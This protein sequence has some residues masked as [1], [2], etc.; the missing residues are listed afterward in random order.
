VDEQKRL[1]LA[2][3]LIALIVVGM[4]YLWPMNTQ[5]DT[6]A[7]D[8]PDVGQVAETEPTEQDPADPQEVEEPQ[9][10]DSAH[11]EMFPEKRLTLR[12]PKLVV[13]VNTRSGGLVEA[14]LQDEQFREG[15]DEEMRQIDLVSAPVIER[16]EL[17]PMAFQLVAKNQVVPTHTKSAEGQG[18]LRMLNHGDQSRE[19][20]ESAASI[21]G[22]TAA[23]L[24]GGRPYASLE[25]V[26][27]AIEGSEAQRRRTIGKLLS[28]AWKDGFVRL[29]FEVLAHDEEER[30]VLRGL[31]AEQIEVRRTISIIGDYEIRVRDELKN[32]GSQLQPVRERLTTTG[33]E[34][35]VSGGG[36][37]GRPVGQISG[38][39]LNGDDMVRATRAHLAGESGGCAMMSCG[40]APGPDSRSGTIRFVSIDRHY[41][42]ASISPSQAWGDSTCGLR[43]NPAGELEVSVEPMVFTE[44]PAGERAVYVSTL[45]LGPK[46]AD[47]LES[48]A[49]GRR[50]WE[51]ID[52]GWFAPLSLFLLRVL[53]YF[54]GGLGN[55]G[56]SIILLTFI[57]KL[58]LLPV[59]HKTFKNMRQMQQDMGKLKPQLDELNQRYKDSPDVKQ[60]KT[61]ELY[62]QNGI[63][64]LK[65]VTGCLPMF[66]QMPIWIALYRM[67]SESV[68]LYRAPFFLWLNDL[69]A[70]DPYYILPGLLGASMFVQQAITPSPGMDNQQQKMMKWMMPGMFT[71]I[72]INMP[73]GLVL[74]IFVNTLLTIVQQQFINRSLPA[75]EPTSGKSATSAATHDMAN[76]GQD[77]SETS[78]SQG[79]RAKRRKRK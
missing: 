6:L 7:Q 40:A 27:R 66:L 78:R 71:L 55:W 12:T 58:L 31:T 30:V 9:E 37:Y 14:Q 3:G 4:T 64:P 13:T 65:Q 21:E 17:I 45:Y 20:L 8:Q 63:N 39:C 48:I 76:E 62:Q 25:A 49:P 11:R 69:S 24:M 28:A 16:P 75:V 74:Y 73:S 59:T 34:K 67:I 10:A 32:L 41:F 56:L 53:R 43:A 18:V 33:L 15:W 46:Q 51:A 77:G 50:L 38:L 42:M 36:C 52:Y 5:E 26:E 22:E 72:M 29:D 2:L 1:L 47:L 70:Q 23:K 68:E 54:H 60:Q 79:K 61:L 19:W 57:I 44:L 35:Q